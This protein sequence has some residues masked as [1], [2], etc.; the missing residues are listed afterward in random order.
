MKKWL[1]SGICGT[2]EQYIRALFIVDLVKQRGWNQK[3]KKKKKKRK[4][5]AKRRREIQPN[6]N[7]LLVYCFKG[8]PNS[9]ILP[10]S[11][12]INLDE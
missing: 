3:N 1:K 10:V 6:P 8:I 4:R 2:Y 5:K 9:F 7:A 11:M 12:V